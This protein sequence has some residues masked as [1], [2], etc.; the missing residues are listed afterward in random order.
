MKITVIATG[1]QRE[2]PFDLK[3][4]MRPT[5]PEPVFE[6]RTAFDSGAPTAVSESVEE[7]VEAAASEAPHEEPMPLNDLEMPAV[8]RRNRQLFQ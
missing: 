8:L 1:F 5:P 3:I 6:S 4:E 7:A 2:N